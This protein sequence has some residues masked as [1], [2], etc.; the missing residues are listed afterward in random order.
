MV[1]V[2][3][4]GLT[5]LGDYGG[6]TET[7][8]VLPGSTAIGA[9]SRTLA[10]A[11]DQRG[12][13]RTQ[14][15][16]TDVGA[17]ESR[18]FTI[19]VSGGNGQGT[20]VDTSVAAALQVTVASAFNE[21]V[22][23]GVVTFSV[24]GSGATATLSSIS[25]SIGTGGVAWVTATAND[26]VGEFSV[27]ASASGVATPA[28]FTLNNDYRPTF[29][30][31]TSQADTYGTAFV[32][33]TGSLGAG[34]QFPAGDEISVAVGGVSEFALIGD[35]GSFSVDLPSASLGVVSSPYTP[36]YD[37]EPQGFFLGASATSEMTVS[38][39]PLTITADSTS[40][41]YGQAVTFSGTEFTESGLVNGDTVT[42]VALT[43]TGALARAPVAG[44]P[45][46]IVPGEAVGTG[47]GNYT[48]SYVNGGLTF[49]SAA[50]TITADNASKTYGRAVTFAGTEFTESGLV[51]GDTVTSVTLTSVGSAAT[52]PVAGSPYAIMPSGVVGT[53]L[54]NY[55][56]SYV[57]GGLTVDAAALTITA[58]ST[59]KTYG[60]TVTFTGTEFTESG[61]VNGDTVTNVTLMSAGAAETAAVPGSPYTIMPSGAV[62]TGLGN[63]TISYVNGSLSVG[64]TTLSITA[65]SMSKTYGQ[66]VTFSGTE[67]TE[68]GLVNGDTITGVSLTSAGAP[69][70]GLRFLAR[71]MQSCPAERRAQAWGTT[72][73]ATLTAD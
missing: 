4:P 30:D 7:I 28:S 43:S 25:A 55:S 38:P 69:S 71:R 73:S 62:G 64:A 54:G 16:T 29:S 70:R 39:A 72:R 61:L 3:D 33:F 58:D 21:P 52:A 14:G 18:G 51:N 56:I 15:S 1:G 47:L 34:S 68:S 26:T 27:T 42:D 32:T 10:P 65:D 24:P 6:L 19:T 60:Q 57:D 22:D 12:V 46:T 49:Q 44:P 45:Y 40:K 13:N 17:F 50:L 48:I 9:G 41:T 59:S 63:Y 66:T 36:S 11:T 37:F 35:D 67:F 2:S 31:I 20:Q 8:A 5:S 23:G 53:G